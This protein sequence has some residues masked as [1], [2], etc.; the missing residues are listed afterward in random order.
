MTML[1]FVLLWV[2]A[3]VA[4]IAAF[5]QLL[6]ALNGDVSDGWWVTFLLV[7]LAIGVP[8]AIGATVNTSPGIGEKVGTIV[9][10]A[11]V[12][13]RCPTWEAQLVRGG[14]SG[15]SGVAGTIPFD[16]T[17]ETDVLAEQVRDAMEHS[18]EVRLAYR[19]DMVRWCASE[20]G[21]HFATTITA[22][23]AD[24]VSRR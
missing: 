12:G 6:R 22:M 23:P 17:I 11:K 9:K 7:A 8:L 18:R 21:N 19:T 20:S 3:A 15:G 16:F 1:T 14:F 10:L 13:V 4:F 2:V 5:V 24:S